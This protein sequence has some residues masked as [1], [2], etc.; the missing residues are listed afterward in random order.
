MRSLYLIFNA[1]V[2]G[3]FVSFSDGEGL[4]YVGVVI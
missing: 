1:V 3:G 2:N 4:F